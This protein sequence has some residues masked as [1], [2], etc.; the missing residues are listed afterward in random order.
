MRKILFFIVLL[1]AIISLGHDVYMYTQDQNKG[2]GL[3]DVGFLWDKYHKDSHD[4]WKNKLHDIEGIVGELNPIQLDSNPITQDTNIEKKEYLEGFSQNDSKGVINIVKAPR[5]NNKIKE[6]ASAAQKNIGF[7]LEQKAVFVFSAFAAIIFVLN[8]L[9]SLIF[10]EKTS[11]DKFGKIKGKKS[12]EYK[13]G[14][15]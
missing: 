1:P 13:Y 8:F 11:T 5:V 14:R 15:K 12:G 9:I 7:I 4:Q 2:F 10:R 6:P 3:S